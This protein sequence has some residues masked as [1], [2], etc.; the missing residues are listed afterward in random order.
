MMKN[1]FLITV[2]FKLFAQA[3]SWLNLNDPCWHE[4]DPNFGD[5]NVLMDGQYVHVENIQRNQTHRYF[6]ETK[7]TTLIHQRDSYRKLILNLEPCRGA[8]YL[9]VRKTRPCYP[10]P[11]S[12]IVTGGNLGGGILGG[13][14]GQGA[15][16][17]MA[18]AD[19]R[20][21]HFMSVID[22]TRDGAPTFFELPLTSTKYYISVYAKV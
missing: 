15:E 16:Y 22:G 21:T 18:D 10:N 17:L 3:S 9:F 1:L 12:C 11:Y 8:V 13:E 4:R 14:L 19:C 7:N 6:F 20:W 5:V 2:N